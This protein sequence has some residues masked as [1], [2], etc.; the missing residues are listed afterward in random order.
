MEEIDGRK[1]REHRG[2]GF[3]KPDYLHLLHGLAEHLLLYMDTGGELSYEGQEGIMSINYPQ[4][5]NVKEEVIGT[6]KN[7]AES[8]GFMAE[9]LEKTDEMRISSKDIKVVFD[10]S[11]EDAMYDSFVEAVRPYLSRNVNAPKIDGRQTWNLSMMLRDM[12]LLDNR[13]RFLKGLLTR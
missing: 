7:L 12:T 4:G 6:L 1:R 10:I 8:H 2:Q 5:V 9:Y 11:D 13:L 3:R